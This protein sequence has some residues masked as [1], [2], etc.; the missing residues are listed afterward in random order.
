MLKSNTRA[1]A[2]K[3]EALIIDTVNDEDG[4][5]LQENLQITFENLK[6]CHDGKYGWYPVWRRPGVVSPANV[7]EFIQGCGGHFEYAEIHQ[8]EE[9]ADLYSENDSEKAAYIK[10]WA[11]VLDKKGY[12]PIVKHY[13][14]IISKGLTKLFKKHNIEA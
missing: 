9:L 12:E 13:A 4:A 11:E 10:R 7:Q 5:N 3:L 8:I 2:A 14:Y 6:A 1:F